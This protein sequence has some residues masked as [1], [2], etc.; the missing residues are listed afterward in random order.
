MG[1]GY[2]LHKVVVMV[3]FVKKEFKSNI[4]PGQRRGLTASE[5]ISIINIIHNREINLPVGDDCGSN[6]SS[7]SKSSSGLSNSILLQVVSS[8][9]KH[10]LEQNKPAFLH[11]HALLLHPFLHLHAIMLSSVSGAGGSVVLIG[12][13]PLGVFFP[14]KVFRILLVPKPQLYLKVN[15]QQM[16]SGGILGWRE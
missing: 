13:R 7:L 5:Y 3:T 15:P 14:S 11:P 6:S 12:S 2:C 9:F 16:L 1:G 10:S 4:F 8:Q